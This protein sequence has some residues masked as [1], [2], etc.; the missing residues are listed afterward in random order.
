MPSVEPPARCRRDYTAADRLLMRAQGGLNLL[1]QRRE[2]R[3]APSASHPGSQAPEA[4]LDEAARRHSAGLMRVNHAGEIAAQA[5]YHGQAL[6]A[7]NAGLRRHLLHA[8][9]EER[10]HLQWCEARL[11]ELGDRPSRLAPI[12]YA[13]SF[14]IGAA[15][16]VAG[17]RTSLGFVEE[18]ERQ[19]VEHLDEHLGRLPSDD[20]R[21][22][23]ILETMRD[24]EARHG[25]DAKQAG[26]RQLPAPVRRLMAAVARVM[27]F[28]AYR[29]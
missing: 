28:G 14:A 16:G 29:I 13:G 25:R 23:A 15:A 18:T 1:A 9:D 10:A 4:A 3:P 11:R 27:K 17:D 8:A 20:R 19:V 24:D 22:R 2:R 7:R 12:W 26:A 5:L 21:S 6:T